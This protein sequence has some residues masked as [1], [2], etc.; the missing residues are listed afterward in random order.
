MRN[1][2]RRQSITT[3]GTVVSCLLLAAPPHPDLSITFTP[4]Y[5]VQSARSD[6]RGPPAPPLPRCCLLRLQFR[7]P[8]YL[9]IMFEKLQQSHS[10]ARNG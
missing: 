4:F 6:A 7:L 2:R 5:S 1:A 9:P 10:L 8:L 3:G